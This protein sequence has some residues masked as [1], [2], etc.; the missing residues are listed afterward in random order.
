[1]PRT[2]T[3]FHLIHIT[4]SISDVSLSHTLSLLLYSRLYTNQV[5]HASRI[6]LVFRSLYIFPFWLAD[7]FVHTIR[8]LRSV[9]LLNRL[10]SINCRNEE[11]KKR[12]KEKKTLNNEF[13]IIYCY[14]IELYAI[15]RKQNRTR[16]KYNM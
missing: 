11:E 7:G 6:I 2:Y 8:V 9:S 10:D 15:Q 3:H 1:M 5:L 13:I 12:K 4:L 14:A 16:K